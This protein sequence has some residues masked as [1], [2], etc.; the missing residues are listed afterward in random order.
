M[1]GGDGECC[2]DLTA[3]I[4]RCTLQHKSR[5]EMSAASTSEPICRRLNLCVSDIKTL[6]V[7]FKI[8]A[9]FFSP[10][11]TQ[12]MPAYTTVPDNSADTQQH[13]MV[14]GWL[15]LSTCSRC[16]NPASVQLNCGLETDLWEP[17]Q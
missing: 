10:L 4:Y 7:Y 13:R 15:F 2:A 5:S 8:I 6:A 16:V 3:F 12:A 9:F 1:G 11:S 14:V 17:D